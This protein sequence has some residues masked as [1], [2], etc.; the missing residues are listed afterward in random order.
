MDNERIILSPEKLQEIIEKHLGILI[1]DSRYYCDSAGR[2]APITSAICD[3]IQILILLGKRNR[4]DAGETE[5]LPCPPMSK[6]N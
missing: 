2:L 4:S 6:E 1:D 5:A 3:C